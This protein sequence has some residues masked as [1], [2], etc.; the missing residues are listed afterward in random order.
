MTKQNQIA[1]SEAAYPAPFQPGLEFNPPAHGVWNIVHVGM[2]VPEAQ[3]IYV[4]AINCMRGVIL[5]AAEMN[6]S[7]R[8][9]FVILQEEDLLEGTV[10]DIT[11]EGIA[12]V[13]EKLP[14]RP[15]AVIVFTVCL[16][17]FLGSDLSRI[18][19]AL[20]AR[21]PDIDFIRA[22]M[23][24]ITQ[25]G[26]LSPDTRLRKSIFDPI[27]ARPVQE[28]KVCIL[29][30]D[31]PLEEDSDLKKVLSGNGF[32]VQELR[33]I[34]TYEEYKAM[35][36]A[37]LYLSVFPRA[38]YGAGET[39]KRLG[40]EH[41]YLPA[42]FDYAEI[43]QE[44]N[45]LCAALN[46]P[47]VDCDAEARSCEDAL[48]K[49]KRLVGETPIV[50]DFTAHPRPLGL[51]RLLLTHG[52]HVEAVFL[53]SITAEE[54]KDFF[55]LKEH[56]PKLLLR[57]TNQVACRTVSRE[58]TEKVLAV[59]QIAAWSVSTPHFVNMV[60]GAGLWGYAGIRSLLS[61]LE[62]AY[63]HE[64]DTEDLVPRKGLGCESCV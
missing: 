53:D 12:D 55:Y 4:C 54:E 61:M 43:R 9:S 14:K 25:K 11:I 21:Y 58:R 49:T 29:G 32:A 48:R 64:K 16:H 2:Q 10:E 45:T 57:P 39:A 60:E 15:P 1:I 22:T 44:L 7:Q 8:F 27:P 24:P 26:G 50:I 34:R 51:G 59:G 18:Y 56:Y 23:E 47:E 63:L 17:R 62:D 28:K 31:F 3:Q 33:N 6:L 20:E 41:L 5:T 19:G 42:S 35:G 40:R 37:A 30:G 36:D 13:I 52:F 38:A 46:L